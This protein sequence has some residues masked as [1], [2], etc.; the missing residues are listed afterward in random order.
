MSGLEIG[1]TREEIGMSVRF[2]A[3]NMMKCG[4]FSWERKQAYETKTLD[5]STRILSFSMPKEVI[6]KMLMIIAKIWED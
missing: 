4:V 2:M 3:L 5:K 1:V 6:F